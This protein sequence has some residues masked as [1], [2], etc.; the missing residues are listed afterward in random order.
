MEFI[1][2]EVLKV[3]FE[4]L[5]AEPRLMAKSMISMDVRLVQVHRERRGC[6]H[7]DEEG[8]RMVGEGSEVVGVLVF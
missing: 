8:K 5:E 4:L 2:R 1:F 6:R 7:E 3:V